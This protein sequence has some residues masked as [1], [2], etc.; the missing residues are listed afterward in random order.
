M[1]F[2]NLEKMVEMNQNFF[3]NSSSEGYTDPRNQ[4][5][6]FYVVIWIRFFIILM[7]FLQLLNQMRAFENYAK[8]VQLI[9]ITIKDTGYFMTFL[10]IW[11]AMFGIEFFI[12]RVDFDPD[13][14]DYTNLDYTAI[15]FLQTYRNFLGDLAAPDISF[16]KDFDGKNGKWNK[17]IVV[18]VWIVWILITIMG[19][20]VI[21]NFLIALISQSYES[22]MSKH[23]EINYQ[24]RAALNKNRIF[25]KFMISKMLF[26]K[27]LETFD[28]IVIQYVDDFEEQT[29]DWLG[30]IQSIKNYIKKYTDESGKKQFEK[31][32]AEMVKI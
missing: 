25:I 21:L 20:I 27:S 17:S 5:D 8:L 10:V 14:E 4:F 12:L 3:K 26:K 19:L 11:I 22:V 32:R 13:R 7:S 31:T 24:Q 15:I 29:D 9:G 18:L 28:V 6:Q 23:K 30:F 2:I 1:S 16:W